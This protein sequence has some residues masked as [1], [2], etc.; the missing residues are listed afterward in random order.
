[1]RVYGYWHNRAVDG[2]AH[3]N[4]YAHDIGGE[5]GKPELGVWTPLVKMTPPLASDVVW[6]ANLAR[7]SSWPGSMAQHVEDAANR[8]IREY[9]TDA[10]RAALA[11][12]L[13]DGKG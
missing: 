1:V 6:L 7:G 4:H 8:V 13:R 11:A 3:C 9:G 2:K 12:M 5:C 10:D